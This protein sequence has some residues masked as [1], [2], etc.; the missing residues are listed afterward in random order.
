MSV[1]DE[2]VE[3]TADGTSTC[4][5]TEITALNVG[6]GI[7]DAVPTLGLTQAPMVGTANA[8]SIINIEAYALQI[9]SAAATGL[10]I[11]SAEVSEMLLASAA[12]NGVSLVTM[13]QF[14]AEAAEAAGLTTIDVPQLLLSSA[15]AAAVAITDTTST[16]FADAGA[17]AAGSIASSGL[18]ELATS[19][20]AGTGTITL[21][22][23]VDQLVTGTG[24]GASVSTPSVVP[25]T[26]L[27]ISTASGT[28]M[29]VLQTDRQISVFAEAEASSEV[30]FKD[31]SRI[32]WVMN[33]ETAAA[34][35]YDNFD[36]DSIAQTPSKVLA[37]GPDGLYE[38]TGDDDSGDPIDAEITTGFMDFGTSNQKHV[39]AIY[40]GYTS[41]GRIAVTAETKDSGHP[42]YTYYLEQR[43]ATAPINSRVVP[44]KGLVGRYWRF[45]IRNVAGADFEVFDSS[46]DIAVS[47]RRL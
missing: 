19:S 35:W 7:A 12:A 29:V 16:V 44:G 2:S 1:I 24:E 41:T 22:R 43:P 4:P 32:A 27:L 39:D 45:S 30:S 6:A 36:F 21:L 23:R 13:N 18:S 46:T 20:A 26:Y 31:P 3:A 9:G 10:A 38:L 14:C 17:V 8:T 11:S 33:T 47:S 40:F 5:S 25:G 42:P 37:V 15:I 34:S 28:S